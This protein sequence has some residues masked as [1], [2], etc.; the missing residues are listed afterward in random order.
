MQK[1]VRRLWYILRRDRA[2]A[3]LAE[4]MEFH[5]AMLR[6][7]LG[8]ARQAMG[9]TAISREDAR[10]VWIWPWMESIGQ[11]LAYAGRGFLRQPG[12]TL[13]AVLALACAIGLN[14][15]LFTVFNA[16]ALRPWSVPDPGRVVRAFTIV[17]NPPRGL[18]NINGFSY[19]EYRYLA[20]HSK[21]MAGLFTERGDSGLHLER[22]KA[23]VE[24]VSDSYF[25]VL[26]VGMQQGRGF[27]AGEDNM[28]AP[29]AVAVLSYTAW[30]NRFGGDPGLV[31]HVV[32]LEEAPFTVVGIA[33]ADFAGTSPERTDVW[34]PTGALPLVY[35]NE[36]WARDFERD[37]NVCCVDVAGRLAPGISR[38]QARS[39]LSLLRAEF[40]RT[41]HEQSDGVV[42]SGT[43]VLQKPGRK[44]L[45]IYAVFGVM[46]AA[47][48]LVLL[49]AC[50]NVGNLLLARA[51]ARRKEIA[52]RLSLGAGRR[53]LI[54]Q[55]L[56]ESLAL[57]CA[58]GALGI[59][60]AYVLPGPLFTR[61]VGEVSFRLRPDGTVLLY[62][63]GLA[64]LACIAFGLA[65]AL[66]ATRGSFHDA[67]KQRTATGSRISLRGLL[68]AVQVAI[69][70]IL[71]V[72]AGLL[73]R[74]IQRARS[75]DPGFA[76]DGMAS[77]TLEFPSSAYHGARLNAFYQDLSSGLDGVPFGFSSVEPLGNTMNFA[78]INL[79]GA[80][81]SQSL[82]I[83]T[84]TVSARYFD[85][86]RIPIVEGRN[87]QPADA[88]APVVLVNQAMAN[89]Y[90]PGES[91]V[92]RTILA[93]K[94]RQIIGVARNAHTVG[95]DTVQPIV[96]Y[97]VSFGTTP[98]LILGN[99]PA[100]LAN[101]E[102]LV[103]RLDPRVQVQVVPLTRNMDRWLSSS[104]MGA[105]I[106]GMLGML[107]LALASIGVSG[108]FAYAVQQRTQEIGI[109]MALGAR[110]A[111]V[112][113]VVFGWAARSL[114]AGLAI[115]LVGAVAASR[116]LEQYLL[117]LSLL[118]PIA[119]AAAIV[120]LSVAGLA[121]TYLPTRS[122]VKLDPVQA[123]RQE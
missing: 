31:G 42:L 85:V 107:A 63:F 32:H 74:A 39:E 1:L 101:V 21:S 65:P 113:R 108:V 53:R 9:N 105:V 122:A 93:G 37:P 5:Q 81:S 59:G 22:A 92:G 28:G 40:D 41:I 26:E 72:G 95:L 47:V 70:V 48:M 10:A 121:A 61:A 38:A 12:F 76:V 123:L 14:T 104:R 6:Q 80:P 109:R 56:T 117:G 71:L 20:E 25:R 83:L 119:Y 106:A 44:V 55:L 33:P 13:V 23:R 46:F 110:P 67:L 17:K 96:Y 51:A 98:R 73:V 52:V 54:R 68:L 120:V 84:N 112:M 99:T 45:Q 49:L 86:L 69:S 94:P 2:D 11:D 90:F 18:D 111:Q 4:E 82:A 60:L 58:A 64:V 50:A 118:D 103:K 29:Q 7:Q 97:P 27:L 88:G 89:R 16:I 66:H 24:T 30:Q 87:F 77:I 15:S 114:V 43:P 8:D 57:A 100:N 78:K 102:A 35:P 75:H 62:T 116:L 79:P 34:I 115:G 36:T 19:G 91:A 3:E